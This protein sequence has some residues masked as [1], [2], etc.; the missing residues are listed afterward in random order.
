MPDG[1]SLSQEALDLINAKMKEISDAD[2]PF[3]RHEVLTDEAIEMFR[4]LG[5]D[6][7]V[8]LLETSADLYTK[9]YTLDGTP[10]YY[11]EALVPST[12]YLKVWGLSLYRGGMLLRVPDRPKY[13]T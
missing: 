11:Y 13:N 6:D 5:F 3:R 9:Y 4:E 8:S 1:T 2:I 10:D 7:K 12:G